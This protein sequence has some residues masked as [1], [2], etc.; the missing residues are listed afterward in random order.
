MKVVTILGSASAYSNTKKA[1]T[2]V[3]EK[4]ADLGA[5]VTQLNFKLLPKRFQTVQVFR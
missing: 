2:V 3:E 4:F 5:K 1:L